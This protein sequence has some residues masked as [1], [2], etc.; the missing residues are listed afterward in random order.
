MKPTR[1]NQLR[2]LLW[3][4]FWLLIFEGAL[5]RW[6]LPGLASPLLLVRDP[7]A[8]L[9]VFWAW[10]LL[11]KRPW[12]DWIKPLFW[13][14]PI[15]FVLAI[16]VGHGD[17]FTALYGCRILVLQLPL[18]FVFGSV[19][20][21]DDVIRFAWVMLWLCIP[22]AL[23]ITTQSSLPQTHLLNVGVG[24]VGTATFI[25]AAGRFRP[26]GT[27][28]FIN[29]VSMFFSLA[30]ASLFAVFYGDQ[31]RT[32]GRLFCAIA[33]IALVVA[34][35]VSISRGLLA[36][37]LQVIAALI[38]ALVL[39]RTRIMPVVCGLIALIVAVWIA[40]SLPGFQQTSAAFA[41]RWELAAAAE[42]Q[43]SSSV[44]SS[45]LGVF[46]TRILS[47]YTDPL[48]NLDAVPIL[49]YGIGIG[50]NVGAKRLT[51]ELTF[52][53]GEG[54]WKSSLGELGL[55]LGL[56]FLIWRLSLALWILRLALRAAAK[57]NRLPLIFT[58]ASFLSVLGG[59]IGQPT[60]L[61]FLV[62][63]AGLTLAACNCRSLSPLSKNRGSPLAV[64]SLVAE[65]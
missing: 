15:A 49:G 39:S 60:G 50:S 18:I 14:A 28:S 47:R 29:G 38:A 25:G 36:G 34:V 20:N 19:F 11:N 9:A 27:F 53:V 31:I 44:V 62:L 21:R 40:T 37:Y 7:I 35:P 8:L 63:S 54:A 1:L 33:A 2:R 24:G 6:F 30:V 22:M 23:L 51:G 3:L 12:R 42:A 58:G 32:L 4:Y 59:Q 16:T 26:P 52:L 13:I 61:G 64:P 41:T 46:E 43:D 48:S 17:L 65:T 45:G 56:A 5:R 57:G 10:P 55:P